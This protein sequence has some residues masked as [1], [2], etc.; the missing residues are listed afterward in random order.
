MKKQSNIE[1]WREGVDKLTNVAWSEVYER[2]HQ[3]LE[4]PSTNRAAFIR[5]ACGDN[6]GQV[7]LLVRLIGRAEDDDDQR[8]RGASV[9]SVRRMLVEEVS[10]SDLY[11]GDAAE[12]REPSEIG[13]YRIV[14]QIGRGGMATV[15]LAE[16]QD[17][18]R[19][20]V[21]IKVI[22]SD[23]ASNRDVIR[24][25]KFERELLASLKHENIAPLFDGGSTD[26][27]HP[28]F[29]M[30]F[31]EGLP[32]TE[33]CRA[34]RLSLG[35]RLRLF[36]QVVRAVAHAHRFGV[37]HRDIKPGNILV[38]A[39]GIPKLVDFG[40]AKLTNEASLRW[41]MTA[42][43]TGL[44]PFTPAYAS[45][46]Q[47][48]GEPVQTSTDVYSLG[49]VLYELL[50]GRRPFGTEHRSV[51]EMIRLVCESEPT[52]PSDALVRG[53]DDE[54][55][56]SPE[57]D[58]RRRR[59]LRGDLD[60]I[61][62]K[63][64]RREPHDRYATV[65]DLVSDIDNYFNQRPVAARRGTFRYF[66]GKFIRRHAAFVTISVIA[67]AALIGGLIVTTLSLQRS[68]EIAYDAGMS[69]AQSMYEQGRIGDAFRIMSQYIPSAGKRDLRDFEFYWLWRQC[70]ERRSFLH[71]P[72][73]GGEILAIGGDASKPSVICASLRSGGEP[74]V[75]QFDLDQTLQNRSPRFHD[76]ADDRF[77][78]FTA[79]G[80]P[81]I[82][83]CIES[84][85]CVYFERDSRTT[86]VLADLETG[87]VLDKHNV[88]AHFPEGGASAW[89]GPISFSPDGSRA[90]SRHWHGAV[91]IWRITPERKL[92]HVFQF[93]QD[94][95][96]GW[97]VAF[98]PS[99]DRLTSISIDGTV[100]VWSTE[101]FEEI[102]NLPH[103]KTIYCVCW[104]HDG[105]LLLTGNETDGFRCW[106]AIDGTLLHHR[107]Q[108]V[109]IHALAVSNDGRYLAVG[110]TDTTI[111]LI[112]WHDMEVV[113]EYCGHRGFIESLAFTPDGKFLVSG[114][115][116][117]ELRFWRLPTRSSEV[118][119]R[120]VTT[121]SWQGHENWVVD[122]AYHPHQAIFATAGWEGDVHVWDARD[123][124]RLD[125]FS[126]GAPLTG[127]AYA[128]DGSQLVISRSVKR[129]AYEVNSFFWDPQTHERGYDLVWSTV[130][131]FHPCG[132]W[133]GDLEASDKWF[134]RIFEYPSMKELGQITEDQSG[135]KC[136][137]SWANDE[138]L[139]AM[140][141]SSGVIQFARIDGDR[142]DCR[143]V[144]SLEGSRLLTCA[145]TVDDKT[146]IV[147]GSDGLIHWVDVATG[148]VR[149]TTDSRSHVLS[150][151]ISSDGR[152]LAT[153][154]R[155]GTI[156]L[157][158]LE[159]GQH[160]ITFKGSD[161]GIKCI[162]FSPDGQVLVAGAGDGSVHLWRA[163]TDEEFQ[164][165]LP[166]VQREYLGR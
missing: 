86:L 72:D 142:I 61:V 46:E 8:L 109:A 3:A 152:R 45:P 128:P 165:S 157:W 10:P 117:D 11:L 19:Q 30:E 145:F 35:D 24:R 59:E 4:M 138:P 71:L 114:D 13:P 32:I 58:S 88:E 98:S 52:R 22:R 89:P 17:E 131:S 135:D 85:L 56:D 115:V 162:R 63:S 33:Y 54:R 150:L 75:N 126:I 140:A 6:T 53:G 164:E 160:R 73:V 26:A 50:T 62:L 38:T 139:V 161:A 121:K 2:F 48:R 82:G 100:R 99:G 70:V 90:A 74:R 124:R 143:K 125:T 106:N 119:E 69:N 149:R 34:Q 42:T 81:A 31:V 133:F 23:H 147:S 78:Y 105:T 60:C 122:M 41:D 64:L 20:Q 136:C 76:A 5:Q 97:Q 129:D 80:V 94:L 83:C 65:D 93:E 132:A 127:V 84:G 14:R 67:L 57:D 146:L 113:A 141:E 28:Y 108:D 66:A 134:L 130:P 103:P 101:T 102:H 107:F 79:W 92:E 163:A 55:A 47:V 51:H 112:T 137:A 87:A 104:N 151:A 120:G 15:Y 7:E 25:F 118:D 158:D 159:T 148:R 123:G 40:I 29:V 12:L 77:D 96:G 155:E 1:A 18:F 156:R 49:V 166:W 68:E 16:R 44:S 39:H 91:V 153:A 116:A 111:R 110:G 154:S 37:V 9:I 27:G 95:E 36:Q 144:R 21:A 43:A